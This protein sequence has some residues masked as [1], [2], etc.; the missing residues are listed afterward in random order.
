MQART[1]SHDLYV[2]QIYAS[3][4]LGRTLP[5]HYCDIV[6]FYEKEDLYFNKVIKILEKIEGVYMNTK[7]YFTESE[8]QDVLQRIPRRF[9]DKIKTAMLGNRFLY[10]RLSTIALAR[11]I[12][13]RKPQ[14]LAALDLAHTIPTTDLDLD[15]WL[16]L[17][18]AL[19]IFSA[20]KE[21]LYQISIRSQTPKITTVTFDNRTLFSK[22][23]IERY[24]SK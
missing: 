5:Q 6:I 13:A 10:E 15:E 21:Y 4:A 2:M 20:S 14:M 22:T 17:S 8:A 9:R 19:K 7:Y 24:N 12:H 3:T 16:P 23:D 1:H 11:Q 18:Q